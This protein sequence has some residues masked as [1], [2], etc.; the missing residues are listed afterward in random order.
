MRAA[1]KVEQIREDLGKV[2]PVIAEQVEEAMLGKRARLD[3]EQAER[4][5]E[6]VRRLLKFER[7][8]RE[9]IAKHYEQLQETRQSLHL[10]PENVQTVVE[11]ALQLAG[12]PPLATRA[13]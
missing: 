9:Q 4:S 7:D 5:A 10:T 1:Q 2:G 6:P 13:R 8:L 3:T 12:Q 11:V